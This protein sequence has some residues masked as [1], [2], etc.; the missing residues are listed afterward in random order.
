MQTGPLRDFFVPLSSGS[1]KHANQGALAVTPGRSR[2][3]SAT[4]RLLKHAAGASGR[5]ESGRLT[6]IEAA[7]RL[8]NSW[9][10]GVRR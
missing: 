4:I 10:Y 3:P 5:R 6:Q 9:A 8:A 1:L 7:P 2:W